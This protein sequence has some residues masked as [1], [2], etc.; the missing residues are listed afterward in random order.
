MCSFFLFCS[1]LTYRE[2]FHLQT[3]F[4]YSLFLVSHRTAHF[5]LLIR[6]IK[7]RILGHSHIYSAIFCTCFLF[8][9]F[10]AL[11]IGQLTY[12]SVYFLYHYRPSAYRSLLFR[13]FADSV[14]WPSVYFRSAR[15]YIHTAADY[16]NYIDLSI[17]SLANHYIFFRL[18]LNLVSLANRFL[19][20]ILSHQD[21]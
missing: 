11:H 16:T 12:Q 21:R 15:R 7:H 8:G 17:C 19:H 2:Q 13:P 3:V 14:L 5:H 6:Y 20:S 4:L 10:L 1:H 9:S 18:N